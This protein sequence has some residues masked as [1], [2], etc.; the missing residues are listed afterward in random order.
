MARNWRTISHQRTEIW[1]SAQKIYSICCISEWTLQCI[2]IRMKYIGEPLFPRGKSSLAGQRRRDVHVTRV[3]G[4]L[5]CIMLRF[6]YLNF[7]L[8]MFVNWVISY[9]FNICVLPLECRHF[10]PATI[11][12]VEQQL[13]LLHAFQ[14]HIEP[15]HPYFLLPSGSNH[16]F[17]LLVSGC[18][19]SVRLS[20]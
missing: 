7:Y 6:I 14:F 19:L 3:Q 5:D 8:I 2:F 17:F 16:L 11:K 4:H 20:S 15:E 1:I 12:W 9:N 13:F 10:L 18:C